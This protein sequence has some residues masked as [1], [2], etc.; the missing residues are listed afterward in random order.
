[1]KKYLKQVGDWRLIDYDL[2]RGK[3]NIYPA[4]NVNDGTRAIMRR[5]DRDGQGEHE[6]RVLQEAGDA[7]DT[8]LIECVEAS[9]ERWLARAY[10]E[11]P[12]LLDYIERGNRERFYEISDIVFYSFVHRVKD[13]HASGIVHGD[14]KPAHLLWKVGEDI[15]SLID[16]GSSFFMDGRVPARIGGTEGYAAPEYRAGLVTPAC[17]VFSMA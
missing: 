11:Y 17:D 4:E 12:T 1:M 2:S 15:F 8:P 14:L 9:G 13:L 3:G 7:V 10:L 16:Y 6:L 5:C